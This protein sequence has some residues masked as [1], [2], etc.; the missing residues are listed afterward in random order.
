MTPATTAREGAGKPEPERVTVVAAVIRRG[1]EFLL[2][3]RPPGKRHGGLWEFPG[4]KV[5]EDESDREALDRELRE[6]LGVALLAAGE[7]V[8]E[9]RDPGTVF[10][11][12]FR[13]TEVRGEPRPLEHPEIRWVPRSG[14]AALELA[15]SDARFVAEHLGD[16]DG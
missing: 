14:L 2:A 1:E 5:L 12:R 7:A 9:A 10:V 11:V 4:G 3:R 13:F 16:G 8:C 6:E 15:P